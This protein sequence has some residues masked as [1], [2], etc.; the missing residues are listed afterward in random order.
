[1]NRLNEKQPNKE[2]YTM[3]NS[4]SL[5]NGELESDLTLNMKVI[6]SVVNQAVRE[7]K[8]EF[9]RSWEKNHSLDVREIK[10]TIEELEALKKE[11]KRKMVREFNSIIAIEVSSKLTS[12]INT[13]INRK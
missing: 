8:T 10:R 2:M 3:I 12:E 4:K 1:M 6:D 9:L 5:T 7:C 11:F 13:I